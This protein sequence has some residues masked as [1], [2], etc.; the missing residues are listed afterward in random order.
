MSAN[1]NPNFGRGATHYGQTGSIPSSFGT[2]VGMEG[3]ERDFEDIAPNQR[4]VKVK[5]SE[6]FTRAICVRNESG[7]VL[8]PGDVVVW[9]AGKRGL[10]AGARSAVADENCAGVVDDMLSAAGVRNG[11]L[12]WLLFK[13]PAL[14]NKPTGGGTAIAEEGLVMANNAGQGVAAPAPGSATAARD[15]AM[16]AIGRAITASLDADTQTLVYLDVRS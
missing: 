4:G 16:N 3:V 15:Q 1:V 14:V 11:D 2:S 8:N 13:G 9:A 6:R 5:R 7:G 12:F 10:R